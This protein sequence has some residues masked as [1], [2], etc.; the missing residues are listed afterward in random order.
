[1]S[2][3]AGPP[4]RNLVSPAMD[5]QPKREHGMADRNQDHGHFSEGQEQHHDT[6][7]VMGHFSEGQEKEHPASGHAG[8][9]AEGQ[10]SEE[11]EGQHEDAGTF[12]EGQRRPS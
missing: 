5:R 8:G 6:K 2:P 10:E 7:E 9:F 1:M 3:I 4:V 12:A 11:H